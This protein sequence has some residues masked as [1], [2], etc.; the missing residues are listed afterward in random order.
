VNRLRLWISRRVGFFLPPVGE[1]EPDPYRMW[2]RRLTPPGDWEYRVM[3]E[4]EVA[5]EMQAQAW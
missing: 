2:M 1:W 3:T 5:E 4:D